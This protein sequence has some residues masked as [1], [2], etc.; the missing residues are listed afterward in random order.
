MNS[1]PSLHGVEDFV[2]DARRLGDV[3]VGLAGLAEERDADLSLGG[4]LTA[5]VAHAVEVGILESR[6]PALGR[7]VGGGGVDLTGDPEL[8]GTRRRAVRENDVAGCSETREGTRRDVGGID[9]I[10][11]AKHLD[12]GAEW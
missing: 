4:V 1:E 10:E 6:R 9:E 7:V 2:G 11:I 5:E 3:P 8:P 12:E